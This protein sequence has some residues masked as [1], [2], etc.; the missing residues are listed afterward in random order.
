M[1]IEQE[2]DVE[3]LLRRLL[4]ARKGV[5]AFP[6]RVL[7]SVYDEELEALEPKGIS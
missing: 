2:Q 7:T 5:S 1:E 3:M 4:I 6:E